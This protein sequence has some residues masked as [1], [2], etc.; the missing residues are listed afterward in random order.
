MPSF[1]RLTRRDVD[2]WLGVILGEIRVLT[3]GIA[4]DRT[5]VDRAGMYA[6]L[7][8]LENRIEAYRSELGPR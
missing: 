6:R 5:Q 8:E 2:A 7:R 1:P 4:R 3:K